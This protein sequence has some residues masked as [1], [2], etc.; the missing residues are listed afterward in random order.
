MDDEAAAIVSRSLWLL[1]R[2]ERT[3][4]ELRQYF[5]TRG[6]PPEAVEAAI[7]RLYE[8]GL[9]DDA[10]YAQRYIEG[11]ARRKGF[12]RN[13]IFRELAAKGVDADLAHAALQDFHEADSEYELLAR[14]GRRKW[15]EFMRAGVPADKAR[16]RLAGHL[17]RRGFSRGAII[18]FLEE[19]NSSTTGDR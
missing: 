16:G 19:I 6:E 10:R 15:D 9:L 7:A 14:A 17:Q 2:K 18:R 12:G 3:V 11:P 5:R 13:R 8:M 4:A 1:E